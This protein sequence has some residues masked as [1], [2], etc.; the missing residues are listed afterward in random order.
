MNQAITNYGNLAYLLGQQRAEAT[1]PEKK[2][3]TVTAHFD[4]MMELVI[5][6]ASAEEA[7]DMAQ[8]PV[9]RNAWV[10]DEDSIRINTI[11]KAEE[12]E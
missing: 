6:A 8:H 2:A 7:K 10:I 9:F 1:V 3:Y 12:T 5:Y 4:G 11:W